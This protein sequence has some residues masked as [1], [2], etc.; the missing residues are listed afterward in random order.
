[1]LRILR[2]RPKVTLKGMLWLMAGAA[3]MIWG[4]IALTRL[5]RAAAY[6]RSQASAHKMYYE[7]HRERQPDAVA[8]ALRLQKEVDVIPTKFDGRDP[9]VIAALGH[10]KKM[11]KDLQNQALFDAKMAEYHLQLWQQYEYASSHPWVEVPPDPKSPP[12]P[13]REPEPR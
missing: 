6:F 8:E 7:H 2:K 12:E 10:M 13:E 3:I 9:R 5:Y 4:G 1:M 11:V